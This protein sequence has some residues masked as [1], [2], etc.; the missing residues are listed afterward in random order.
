MRLLPITSLPL[1]GPATLALTSRA[2]FLWLLLLVF[3]LFYTTTKSTTTCRHGAAKAQRRVGE[4]LSSLLL[5]LRYRAHRSTR[6]ARPVLSLRVPGGFLQPRHNSI[7]FHPAHSR[8]LLQTC[9]TQ[10]APSIHTVPRVP[11]S[12]STLLLSITSHETSHSSQPPTCL[13]SLF[14]HAEPLHRTP[15]SS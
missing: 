7:R 6:S 5:A 11:A 10:G 4:R 14:D 9:T 8:P 13:L 12:P 2:H 3:I 15:T 1:L